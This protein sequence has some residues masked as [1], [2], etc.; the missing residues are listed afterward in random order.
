MFDSQVRK[1]FRYLTQQVRTIKCKKKKNKEKAQKL[2]KLSQ[3]GYLMI[4]AGVRKNHMQ[5]RVSHDSSQGCQ[6]YK[7]QVPL[8]VGGANAPMSRWV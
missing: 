8:E 6:N 1:L 7:R 2:T 3:E 4:L 5:V